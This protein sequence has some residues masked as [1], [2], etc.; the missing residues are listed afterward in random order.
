M[1][2][3]LSGLKVTGYDYVTSAHFS[4]TIPNLY[5]YG[6]SNHI[7]FKISGPNKYAGYVYGQGAHFEVTVR[8][9]SA[10]FYDYSGSGWTEF[11]C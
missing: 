3:S 7:E 5:H 9:S 4:G 8:N 6:L 2:I 10:S 11:S 1:S